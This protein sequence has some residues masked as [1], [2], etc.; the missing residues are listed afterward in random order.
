MRNGG[1]D[2][3]AD[4]MTRQDVDELI[5]PFVKKDE[6]RYYGFDVGNG[7]R[8]LLRDLFEDMTNAGWDGHLHQVKQ[9]FGSL[10]VYI[11]KAN[12][13]VFDVIWDAEANSAHICE[14]CGSQ[15][16]QRKIVISPAK[17]RQVENAWYMTLCDACYERTK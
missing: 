11:G 10:R 5:A 2:I 3:R 8:E 1:Y 4:R 7:W 9:K 6:T 14:N 15:G 13:D 12:S 16:E 17:R